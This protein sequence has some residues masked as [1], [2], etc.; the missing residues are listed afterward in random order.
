MGSS[1]YIPQSYMKCQGQCLD[2]AS[3]RGFH[4]FGCPWLKTKLEDVGL[5]VQLVI[6]HPPTTEVVVEDQVASGAVTW[7]AEIQHLE[8]Q[9]SHNQVI[10][11]V[12]N[13]FQAL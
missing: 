13:H 7:E 11:V 8:V 6:D 12:I 10:T 9:G 1:M 3:I 4:R 2:S 5:G